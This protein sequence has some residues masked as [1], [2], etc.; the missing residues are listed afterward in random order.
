MGFGSFHYIINLP[1]DY[2]KIDGIFIRNL[3]TSLVDRLV[4][5]SLVGIA[6]GLGKKTIAEFVGDAATMSLLGDLGVDCAQGYQVGRPK[7]ILEVFD[8]FP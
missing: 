8:A 6:K 5:Q 3:A 4:V 2:L 7:P 1:F